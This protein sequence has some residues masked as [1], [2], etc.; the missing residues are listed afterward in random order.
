MASA[1]PAAMASLVSL[2]SFSSSFL[3]GR[4]D[5]RKERQKRGI[6]RPGDVTGSIDVGGAR[7]AC[8]PIWSMAAA[9]NCDA[10]AVVFAWIALKVS[11]V[12]GKCNALTRL[13]KILVL[14]F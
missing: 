9:A 14:I 8:L 6:T 7:F 1:A 13:S 12:R 11:R 3:P 2:C 4:C 10:L 5:D